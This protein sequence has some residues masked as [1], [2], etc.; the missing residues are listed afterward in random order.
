MRVKQDRFVCLVMTY[1]TWWKL[2][3]WCEEG[4][5]KSF[6][7]NLGTKIQQSRML[8]PFPLINIHFLTFLLSINIGVVVAISLVFIIYLICVWAASNHFELRGKISRA[9][10]RGYDGNKTALLILR[11][12]NFYALVL[13]I[14]ARI[15]SQ[16]F[17]D[18]LKCTKT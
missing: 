8:A 14:G 18:T 9:Y 10:E 11:T 15:L 6:H 3:F 1:H 7:C 2:V 13:F 5:P 17:S 12:D 16:G 4:T